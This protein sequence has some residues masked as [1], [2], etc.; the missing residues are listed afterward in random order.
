MSSSHPPPVRTRAQRRYASTPP[1]TTAAT[2]GQPLR[3]PSPQGFWRGAIT[4]PTHATTQPQAH[5]TPHFASEN[6]FRALDTASTDDESTELLS[7]P[8]ESTDLPSSPE[9][10]A[11]L[12]PAL[13]GNNLQRLDAKWTE[14]LTGYNDTLDAQRTRDDEQRLL[15][16]DAQDE[17][18]RRDDEQRRLDREAQH[19][20]NTELRKSKKMEFDAFLA[21]SKE[22]F[23]V[24]MKEALAGFRSELSSWKTSTVAEVHANVTTLSEEIATL[25]ETVKSLDEKVTRAHGHVT[26]TA[27]PSLS[28][29]LDIL[30]QRATR[31]PIDVVGEPPRLFHPNPTTLPRHLPRHFRPNPTQLLHLQP[32]R[33]CCRWILRTK[34]YPRL[35]GSLL[36][37]R[38]WLLLSVPTP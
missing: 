33:W 12:T 29:R 16:R 32:Y 30:E 8:E 26:K 28:S 7:A 14:I 35:P 24:E 1:N 27:L 4:T 9:P 36:G 5:S 3:T 17:Q 38:L 13:L 18:R 6:T 21:S 31:V 11:V 25:S 34:Q 15:E 10:P 23:A 22:A 37:P 20:I 2:A 19:Q